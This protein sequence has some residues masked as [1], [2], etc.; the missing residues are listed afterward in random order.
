MLVVGIILGLSKELDELIN[1]YIE[2]CKQTR[3]SFPY[4]NIRFDRK[5]ALLAGAFSSPTR[6]FF[7]SSKFSAFIHKNSVLS[8]LYIA[9]KSGGEK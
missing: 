9:D 6:P 7:V 1:K 3:G 4:I 5:I 2:A 8:I